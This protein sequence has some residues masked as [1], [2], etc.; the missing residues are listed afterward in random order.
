M[1]RQARPG[2]L[3]AASGER[4]MDVAA[5]SGDVLVAGADKAPYL[6]QP[7]KMRLAAAST[8]ISVDG[9][10]PEIIVPPSFSRA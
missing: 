10:D 4:W 9:G 8:K 5:W 2:G 1:R 6:P 3:K 7:G